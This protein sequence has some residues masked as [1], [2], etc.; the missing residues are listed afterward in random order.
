MHRPASPEV[1]LAMPLDETIRRIEKKLERIDAEIKELRAQM[2][3]NTNPQ[4][5]RLL[6]L[7]DH[8]RKTAIG[9][10][11]IGQGTAGDVSRHTSRARAVESGYLNQ[12]ERQGLV[13]SFREGRRKI[14][15][16]EEHLRDR[17]S[18]VGR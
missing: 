7:P 13:R 5:G 2:Q 9:L 6:A 12:L 17:L 1:Y 14:F 10:A 3:E 8:L 15:S 16:L 11:K 4:N 18:E